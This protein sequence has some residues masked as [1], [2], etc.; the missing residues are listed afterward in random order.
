MPGPKEPTDY[1][2]DQIMTPLINELL[3]LKQGEFKFCSSDLWLTLYQV[4]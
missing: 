3:E 2:L 4:L 1:A